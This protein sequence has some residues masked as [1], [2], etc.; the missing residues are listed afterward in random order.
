MDER[1]SNQVPR[2]ITEGKASWL[3]GH[4]PREDLEQTDMF[5]PFFRRRRTWLV[6][7]GIV[8]LFATLHWLPFDVQK[9]AEADL[10]VHRVRMGLGIFFCIAFLWLTEAMPLSATALLVPVLASL[11]GILDIRSS[12]RSF[13]DPLIFLFFGGGNGDAEVAGDRG[14]RRAGTNLQGTTPCHSLRV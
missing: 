11:T 3:D 13:A 14:H 7:I 5:R 12:L 6:L 2:H 9:H 10:D 1:K 8:L 4:Y